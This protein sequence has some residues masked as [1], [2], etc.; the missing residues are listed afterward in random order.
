MCCDVELIV[1]FSCSVSLNSN[2]LSLTVLCSPVNPPD[3]LACQLFYESRTVSNINCLLR[4]W[5]WFDSLRRVVHALWA[6]VWTWEGMLL[7]WPLYTKY[8]DGTHAPFWRES[9]KHGTTIPPGFLPIQD[10]VTEPHTDLGMCVFAK[11]AILKGKALPNIIKT[12][13]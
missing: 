11:Q 4:G 7:T 2:T 13:K 8:G 3:S 9:H 10:R 5:V 12:P 6:H 1:F